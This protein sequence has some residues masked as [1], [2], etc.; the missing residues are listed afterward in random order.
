MVDACSIPKWN[1]PDFFKL[2]DNKFTVGLENDNLRWIYESVQG[3]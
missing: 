3:I 2:T 1:C